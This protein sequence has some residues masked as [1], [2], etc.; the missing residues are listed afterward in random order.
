MDVAFRFKGN[1]PFK[2]F[3]EEYA[4]DWKDGLL[5][6]YSDSWKFMEQIYLGESISFA[7][8]NCGD[9]HQYM[10]P[11]D[12]NIRPIDFASLKEKTKDLQPVWQEV[13]DYLEGEP[14]A[15]VEYS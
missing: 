10:C 6:R 7:D 8:C 11:G 5:P 15:Y 12:T 9:L 1:G 4:E 14:K 2:P 13:I 3:P